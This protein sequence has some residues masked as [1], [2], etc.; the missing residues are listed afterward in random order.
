MRRVVTGKNASK[1]MTAIDMIA[2][3]VRIFVLLRLDIE[4]S[5]TVPK[6]P[7]L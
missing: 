7:R 6:L 4:F 2:V 1:K 5:S 3:E